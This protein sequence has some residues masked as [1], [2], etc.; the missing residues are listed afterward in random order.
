MTIPLPSDQLEQAY[1]T[2]LATLLTERTPHGYWTGELS[3]SALS[4]ATAVRAL[5][6]LRPHR[7]DSPAMLAGLIEGGL[8]WLAA[9]QNPDGG[10]GDTARS[11]SNISTSM[12]CRAAFHLASAVEA[13]SDC[14]HKAEYYL[15]TH[16]GQ[17]PAEQAEAIR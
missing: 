4:T 17:T 9:H 8:A 14:L 13:Y 10:W 7:L 16:C 3:T 1:Q 2:A 12:L 15:R 11:L 6:L 5:S